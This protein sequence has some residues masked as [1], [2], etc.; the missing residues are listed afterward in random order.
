VFEYQN[1]QRLA[2]RN[3]KKLSK[4]T[5]LQIEKILDKVK[6]VSYKE[7]ETVLLRGQLAE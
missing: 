4:L 7:G 6:N 5:S 3:H 1:L 2:F